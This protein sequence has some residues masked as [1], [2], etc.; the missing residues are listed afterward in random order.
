[1][2]ERGTGW[3]GELCAAWIDR[4]GPES[5]PWTETHIG[6]QTVPPEAHYSRP[7]PSKTAREERKVGAVRIDT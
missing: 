2:L 4:G 5:D 7:G 3:P 6:W 1:M